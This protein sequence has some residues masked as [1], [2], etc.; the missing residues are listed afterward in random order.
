ME[1]KLLAE[2][3][4]SSIIFIKSL[5]IESFV[6]AWLFEQFSIPA[7]NH[8]VVGIEISFVNQLVLSVENIFMAG[9][10]IKFDSRD[11]SSSST[12]QC[13]WNFQH[14]NIQKTK[15]WHPTNFSATW[16]SLP[17]LT[18]LIYSRT[19]MEIKLYTRNIR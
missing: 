9:Y 2:Q 10:C 3:I 15:I 17:G 13:I 8:H 19:F 16:E 7:L 4:G 18:C 6:L 12:L 5:V 11:S 14:A 1:V